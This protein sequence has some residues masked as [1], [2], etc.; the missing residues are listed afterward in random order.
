MWVMDVMSKN[1]ITEVKGDHEKMD[2]SKY[3]MEK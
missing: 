2:I 1:I 3:T